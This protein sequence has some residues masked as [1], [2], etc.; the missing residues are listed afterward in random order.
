MGCVLDLDAHIIRL[1][2]FPTKQESSLITEIISRKNVL[3]MM[4]GMDAFSNTKSNVKTVEEKLFVV[5]N[6]WYI[7]FIINM[8]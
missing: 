5:L 1:N 7:L 2:K 6:D 8:F 4:D 3:K